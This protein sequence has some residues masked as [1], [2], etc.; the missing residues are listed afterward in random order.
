MA[1]YT[2]PSNAVWF[3]TG[4]STGIGYALCEYLTTN[5]T[6]R[7]VATARNPTAL[8]SLPTGPNIT[9]LALDVTS[10]VSIQAALAVILEKYG[11]I[12]VVVNNAGFGIR[13]DTETTEL[14]HARAVM[15]A[16]FWGA[17]RITQLVLPILREQNPKT[18]AIG[19]LII[20][21]TSMGGRVA[22]PANTFY[23]ASKFA[24]EGFT[25]GL[26]KEVSPDWNIRFLCV[27]PGG[28]KTNYVETST[29]KF[30]GKERHPA[31]TD[32][33]LP[34]NLLFKYLGAPEAMANFAE[35]GKLAEVLVK[36]V[37]EGGEMPLRLPLGMDAWGSLMEGA[38][39]NLKDLEKVKEVAVSISDRGEEQLKSI[40]FLK[41]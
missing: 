35:P 29:P 7:V 24:L 12:D 2:L 33:N 38:E 34:T 1:P 17:A 23:H 16:N 14:S 4:C 3:V 22:F 31:Y 10:D 21:V 9:K 39:A 41:R 11:R 30:D 15:D 13:G 18:G 36:Y 32:P 19:G 28:V 37:E 27:E 26:S 25:E 20:Q 8:N 40:K 5:T 6:S